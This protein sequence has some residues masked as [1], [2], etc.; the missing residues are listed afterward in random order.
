MF[1]FF[2]EG[3]HVYQY[4]GCEICEGLQLNFWAPYCTDLKRLS[5]YINENDAEV[6]VAI[7][8]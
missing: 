1:T 5:M 7:L 8:T 6:F 3:Y 4:W 2:Q